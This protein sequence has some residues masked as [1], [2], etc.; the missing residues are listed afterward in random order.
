MSSWSWTPAWAMP[1]PRS[2]AASMPLI[3][4]WSRSNWIRLR[5]WS[6]LDVAATSAI[7]AAEPAMAWRDR[8]LL[9]GGADANTAWRA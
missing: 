3:V 6:S 5:T 2:A 8:R 1:M 4:A 9:G 7:A